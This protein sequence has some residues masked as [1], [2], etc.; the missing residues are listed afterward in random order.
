MAPLLVTTRLTREDA[1]LDPAR[2]A[3]EL[4]RRVRAHA[5]WPGS[6]V[7]T[8][9]GRLGVLEA[10]VD[11]AHG[12]PPGTIVETTAREPA[13]IAGDRRLLVLHRVRPAGG[14][15][16]AGTDYLRG[17]RELIGTSIAGPATVDTR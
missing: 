6:F 8:T 13:L 4:E 10:G 17:H 2:S 5:G 1:R 11:A 16:M 9:S 14:R 3:Q 12:G 7:E 15:E